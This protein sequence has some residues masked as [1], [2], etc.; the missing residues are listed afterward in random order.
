MGNASVWEFS[1][2]M[3]PQTNFPSDTVICV[4]YEKSLSEKILITVSEVFFLI[5]D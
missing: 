1:F 2:I 5:T 3:L 4:E